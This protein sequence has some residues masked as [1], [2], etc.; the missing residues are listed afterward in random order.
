[1]SVIQLFNN[2]TSDIINSSVFLSDIF[3]N[4]VIIK[5]KLFFIKIFDFSSWFRD[6]FLS[7][8]C[9]KD[10]SCSSIDSISEILDRWKSYRSPVCNLAEEIR[11]IPFEASKLIIFHLNLSYQ[12]L[13]L[14]WIKIALFLPTM[15][16]WPKDQTINM[17]FTYPTTLRL[18]MHLPLPRSGDIIFMPKLPLEN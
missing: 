13:L 18:C 16:N 5:F 11:F 10:V 17:F 9:W 7:F 4:S 1:M 6:Q 8:K 2:N 3:V 14:N 15:V 12:I